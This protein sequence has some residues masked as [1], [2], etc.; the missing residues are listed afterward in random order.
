VALSRLG[1]ARRSRFR[2]S[3]CTSSGSRCTTVRI[4]AALSISC[5]R[6]WTESAPSIRPVP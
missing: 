1:P 6:S 2:A 5:A 3:S 4:F